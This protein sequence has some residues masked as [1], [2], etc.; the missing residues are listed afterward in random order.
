[1]TLGSMTASL[2]SSA[3]PQRNNRNKKKQSKNHGMGKIDRCK[4]TNDI[5]R[6]PPGRRPVKDRTAS[7]YSFVVE[8]VRD[9]VGLKQDVVN[10]ANF[11][12]G[13]DP[14]DFDNSG[15]YYA[16][17]KKD[18]PDEGKG[19]RRVIGKSKK[20]HK[21]KKHRKSKKRRKSKKHCK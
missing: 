4:P 8:G 7:D 18:D 20:R 11:S 17:Y 3:A 15:E 6:L 19:V 16:Y 2:R 5:G 21:S 10:R 13:L 12:V 14:Y 9:T 1:M